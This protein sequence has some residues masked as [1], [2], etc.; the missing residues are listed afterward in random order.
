MPDSTPPPQ[1]HGRRNAGVSNFPK[2]HR[3][4][5]GFSL[6]FLTGADLCKCAHFKV[7][8]PSFGSALENSIDSQ[9]PARPP[10]LPAHSRSFSEA[11]KDAATLLRSLKLCVN[12]L[13]GG[14]SPARGFPRRRQTAAE[15][16][17]RI[18]PEPRSAVVP[19]RAF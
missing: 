16:V 14:I 17:F 15:E 18:I 1:T 11:T 5:Q 2:H 19:S 12:A 4:D 9:L 6:S 10:L 7:C 3:L 8:S 13:E